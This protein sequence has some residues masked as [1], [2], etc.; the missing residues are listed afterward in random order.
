MNELFVRLA[1]DALAVR[2]LGEKR[3]NRR[4]GVTTDDRHPTLVGVRASDLRE[5]ASRTDNVEGGDTEN[6]A[7]VIY[8][9]LLENLG[10]DRDSGVDGVG[11]DE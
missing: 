2:G 5:E 1:L 8:T 11:D 4:A 3:D 9:G 7:R 10:D 6:P